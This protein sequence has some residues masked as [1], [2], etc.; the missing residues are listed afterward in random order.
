[1]F[2]ICQR[3]TLYD[4]MESIQCYITGDVDDGFKV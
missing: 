2:E 1:M 3:N 4:I